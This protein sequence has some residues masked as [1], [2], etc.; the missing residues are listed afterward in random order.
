[1]YA[2]TLGLIGY[3]AHVVFHAVKVVECVCE[4]V[5]VVLYV[6]HQVSLNDFQVFIQVVTQLHGLVIRCD[7][8]ETP[9]QAECLIEILRG[10]LSQS[11]V[12]RG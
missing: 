10:H 11:W 4:E 7:T 6:L 5:K 1:M 8:E 9:V 2:H 3:D 12:G